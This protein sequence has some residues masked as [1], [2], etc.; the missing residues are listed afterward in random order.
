MQV[1]IREQ[2]VMP[3]C[4]DI[5][6][7]WM[8]GQQDDW[9][10]AS[11]VPVAFSAVS[12]ESQS[13]KQNLDVQSKVVEENDKSDQP[14]PPNVL[15]NEHNEPQG[16]LASEASIH[17]INLGSTTSEL[18]RSGSLYGP[19][20]TLSNPPTNPNSQS[21]PQPS[22]SI[23]NQSR[24]SATS[25]QLSSQ[26]AAPLRSPGATLPASASSSIRRDKESDL[27]KPLLD[28]ND[29]GKPLGSSSEFDAGVP[30]KVIDAVYNDLLP[31]SEGSASES[32][33]QHMS[34]QVIHTTLNYVTLLY[35]TNS[36][37]TG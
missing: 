32:E 24:R 7:R 29:Y 16:G 8:M 9:V 1:Q 11:T 19:P 25:E 30:D 26:P 27:T 28:S 31:Q 2:I 36:M 21:T 33:S 20:I 34:N 17:S 14:P 12:S 10:P 23:A 15:S 3:Y 37:M 4:Q 13:S 35:I 18:P 22:T 5:F 6:F